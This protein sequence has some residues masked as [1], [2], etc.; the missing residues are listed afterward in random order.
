MS[1]NNPSIPNSPA[2]ILRL[3]EAAASLEGPMA[4]AEIVSDA[5]DEFEP[6][7]AQGLNAAMMI[8][9]QLLQYHFNTL[10]ASDDLELTP[11]QIRL[12]E[13]DLDHLQVAVDALRQVT[14]D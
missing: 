10:Q 8:L 11:Y 6:S 2:E 7:P 4:F 3:R 14:Q 9:D 12:W 13:R 1:T 5:Q